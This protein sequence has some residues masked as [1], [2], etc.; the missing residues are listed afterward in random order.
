M[1]YTKLSF[2]IVDLEIKKIFK[3]DTYGRQLNLRPDSIA[4]FA[5]EYGVELKWRPIVNWFECFQFNTYEYTDQDFFEIAFAKVNP[6]NGQ[7]IVITDE[8]FKERM[9]FSIAHFKNLVYFMETI[10]PCLFDMQSA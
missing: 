3:N 1:I 7:T 2:E 6:S 5:K 8:C 4:S 9:A 10:Y